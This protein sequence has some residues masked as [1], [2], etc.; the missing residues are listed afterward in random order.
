MAILQCHFSS[1]LATGK[2]AAPIGKPGQRMTEGSRLCLKLHRK[3]GDV[4][5]TYYLFTLT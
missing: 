1:Q 3:S 4:E 5:N 2:L